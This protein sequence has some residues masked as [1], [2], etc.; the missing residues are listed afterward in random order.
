MSHGQDNEMIV[1]QLWEELP[2]SQEHRIYIITDK[3]D[4]IYVFIDQL[5]SRI[6]ST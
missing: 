6:F 1:K 4:M 2:D 5:Q 3:L